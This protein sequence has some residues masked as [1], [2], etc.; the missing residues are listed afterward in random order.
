VIDVSEIVWEP[1]EAIGQQ[2]AAAGVVPPG[3][4]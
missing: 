2:A 1:I 3:G 4:E